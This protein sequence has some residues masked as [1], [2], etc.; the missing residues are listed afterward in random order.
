LK[1]HKF[2]KIKD[3]EDL[4]ISEQKIASTEINLKI[5]EFED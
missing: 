4:K 5:E 2:L 1:T 3:L